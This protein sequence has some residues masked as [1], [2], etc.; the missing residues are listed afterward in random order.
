[1]ALSEDQRALLQL[2]LERGQSYDDIG[3]L[4]GLDRGE[5]QRRARAALG[6]IGGGDP[7]AEV[8]LTD[9]LLGQA[10][11][12]GRADVA[13]HLQGDDEA[14]A[15]AQLLSDKLRVLAPGAKLPTIPAGKAGSGR[16][17]KAKG[18]APLPPPAGEGEAS[19]TSIAGLSKRQQLQIGGLLGAALLVILIVLVATGAFSG[20][21]D[22]SSSGSAGSAAG[23]GGGQT[24]SNTQGPPRAVLRPQDGSNASGVATLGRTKNVPVV[25]L[26]AVNL[27]TEPKGEHYTLWLYRSPKV[28]LRLGATNE[29][30]RGRI[31]A[32]F[33][34][35]TQAVPYIANGSFDQIDVSLTSDADYRA[36]VAKA[37]KKR[38]LPP[39]TGTS[40]LRGRLVGA[41]VGQS[42]QAT[43]QLPNG[44]APSGGAAGS[45]GSGG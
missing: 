9:Y 35:P 4:L 38:T 12:I 42:K 29:S 43:A 33:P 3:S 37:T 30:K 7:D 20:G 15:R 2:L 27:G 25:Q 21:S 40:V 39:Y 34:L 41:G 14:R 32:Q 11:P 45:A 26:N 22:S 6:E 23:A 1:M 19:A 10:D 16:V 8:G 5:A 24:A 28:A 36:E 44:K 18:D 31:L 13:R 17:P